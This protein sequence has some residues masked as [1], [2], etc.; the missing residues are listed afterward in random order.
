MKGDE[1]LDAFGDINPEYI[2]A[3]DKEKPVKKKHIWKILLPV[4]ACLCLIS[5]SV[6]VFGNLGTH[7]PE[8]RQIS[9]NTGGA[10]QEL[11]GAEATYDAEEEKTLSSGQGDE[12]E[13]SSNASTSTDTGETSGSAAS[14]S[15]AESSED[16]SFGPET[17]YDEPFS[18][19]ANV[20]EYLTV[21]DTS[22]RHAEVTKIKP[23]TELRVY[24]KTKEMYYVEIV[25]TGQTGWVNSKYTRTEA[26]SSSSGNQ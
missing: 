1:L 18:V 25:S 4:A 9:E 16:I 26:D 14:A 12:Y 13:N 7:T 19:Y 11:K 17:V 3:A 2:D 23:D 20:N 15:T 22:T 6:A 5:L 8:T 10:G 21:W 24:G